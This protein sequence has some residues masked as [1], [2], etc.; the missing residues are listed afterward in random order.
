MLKYV[1]VRYVV[2]AIALIWALSVAALFLLGTNYISEFNYMRISF[3][4]AMMNI[5]VGF[6]GCVANNSFLFAFYVFASIVGL[7][8]FGLT[9][10]IT[11]SLLLAYGSV[12][13]FF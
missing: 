9:T 13:K 2:S 3:A 1:R 11:F 4:L 6:L 10:P 5:L 7:C 12:Q 8:L